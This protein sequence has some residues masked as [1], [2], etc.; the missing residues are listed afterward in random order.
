[1]D[2]PSPSNNLKKKPGPAKSK[3]KPAKKKA[4]KKIL[5]KE[6]FDEAPTL[7][8]VREVI[9]IDDEELEEA[10]P[11]VDGIVSHFSLQDVRGA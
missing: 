2:K 10:N 6:E 11:D 4:G 5:V 7:T 9:Y 3:K 1:M 8:E